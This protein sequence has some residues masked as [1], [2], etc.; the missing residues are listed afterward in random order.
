MISKC[1][2]LDHAADGHEC[3]QEVFGSTLGEHCEAD[4][5]HVVSMLALC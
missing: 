4:K 5:I 2:T 1:A 3:D